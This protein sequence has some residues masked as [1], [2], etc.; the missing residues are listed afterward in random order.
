MN[1]ATANEPG[2]ESRPE[3]SPESHP[4]WDGYAQIRAEARSLRAKSNLL[5]F[6]NVKVM[7]DLAFNIA[8][9][10]DATASNFLH[11]TYRRSALKTYHSLRSI[12]EGGSWTWTDRMALE[13]RLEQ[14]RAVLE[15]E[16][17]AALEVNGDADAVAAPTLKRESAVRRGNGH[18]PD[19][20]TD[21]ELQVLKC[22]ADGHGTKEVA[23]RLGITF[24]TAA[25][26]RYHIMDKLDIHSTA[27][28][29]RYAIRTGLVKA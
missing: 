13:E 8:R 22:I 7:L 24:K 4:H 14:L 12:V 26:H 18:A 29:V 6:E 15:G 5:R 11:E 20:L 17:K 10:T 2:P 21:R 19:G 9:F 25:C 3:V 23:S 27:S 28:L 16:G 1:S